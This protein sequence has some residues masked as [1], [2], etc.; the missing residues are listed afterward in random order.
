MNNKNYTE[1]KAN[2][3]TLINDNGTENN[4]IDII[5][6]TPIS[7]STDL[8][9]NTLTAS[10]IYNK[11]Y[12]DSIITPSGGGNISIDYGN[13]Y[14]INSSNDGTNYKLNFNF[15]D[16]IGPSPTDSL[17]N[18]ININR[19]INTGQ[20]SLN[21]DGTNIIN[22]INLKRNISD[23]YNVATTDF[24]IAG[25]QNLL[26]GL[27]N[28]ITCLSIMTPTIKTNNLNISNN[29]S[30]YQNSTSL[31]INHLNT[32]NLNLN[33]TIKI[34]SD[35]SGITLN[36]PTTINGALSVFGNV[37]ASNL[38]STTQIDSMYALK[39]D[40]LNNLTNNITSNSLFTNNITGTSGTI[41]TLNSTTATIGNMFT[42]TQSNNNFSPI[43]NSSILNNITS[44]SIF[45][46]SVMGSNITV[47]SILKVAT[48][49][50]ST[51]VLSLPNYY[52]SPQIDN[53]L[54]ITQP[55]LNIRCISDLSTGTAPRSSVITSFGVCPIGNITLTRSGTTFI[56]TFTLTTAHPAGA[57][58][59]ITASHYT[60]ASST[61]GFFYPLTVVVSS[62]T[63]FSVWC[64][65]T[66]N[67]K[68]DASF[69]LISQP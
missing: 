64:R 4:I 33:N 9:V 38:Y 54:S 66:A 15:M 68:Y 57:N 12:I 13:Q 26:N 60:T 51:N 46:P 17:I 32:V 24:L 58:Y 20:N 42:K 43:L 8:I 62:S 65:D 5:E 14:S 2:K 40:K 28:N 7:P 63:A 18:L 11:T 6:N 16:D 25:K 49:D 27:Y 48:L 69:S 50:V 45:S 55:Y 47:S 44:L 22:E 31:N 41:T 52:T 34:Q 23:S 19:N 3:I 30:I 53:L 39:Q 1:I 61:A 21:I 67:N 10:N 56:Y 36:D 35:T 59:N 37:L 29:S